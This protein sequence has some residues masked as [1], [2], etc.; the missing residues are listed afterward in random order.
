MLIQVDYNTFIKRYP[1]FKDFTP[2]EVEEAYKQIGVFISPVD[3][4]EVLV[5]SLRINGVYLATAVICKEMLNLSNPQQAGG[6][7]VISGANEGSDG[8]N[9]VAPPIKTLEEWD[10]LSNN[11]QPYGKALLRI[12]R[13]A[14]PKMPINRNVNVPYYWSR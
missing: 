8:V 1:E 6:M 12:L 7:G 3:D 10:L 4:T 5:T 2:Q 9:F 14:T 13:L 11:L